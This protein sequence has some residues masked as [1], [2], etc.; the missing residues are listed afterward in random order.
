[1]IPMSKLLSCRMIASEKAGSST[2]GGSTGIG[3]PCIG[4][5]IPSRP[6]RR[7]TST[8]TSG[9]PMAAA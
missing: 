4:G 5:M 8:V 1:M 3:Q 2:G 7:D 6:S 9:N